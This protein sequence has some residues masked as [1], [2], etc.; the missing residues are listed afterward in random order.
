MS[1][2]GSAEHDE[3]RQVVRAFL[4]EKSAS[5]EVRRLMEAGE[6]RDDQVW[7]Q[8]A[9]QLGLTG[10]A[11]PERYG[12]A[13]YG[14][15]ELAIVLEEM[16][17]ALLVAPYLATVALAGQAL[18]ASGDEDAMA[19]WLPAIADGSLTATLAVA[20]D[21]GSWDLADVAAVAEPAGDGWVVTGTKLFVIDGHT[22][23]LLLVA[24]QAPDGPGVFAV[25]GGAA[26]LQRARLDTLDLT[27]ALAA[28][29]LRQTPAV[30]IG[31]GQDTAAWL[32]RARDLALA[33]LA[34]EQLGGAA[35]C[36]DLSVSYAKVREQF[37]RPIGSFQA[38][39]HK[40]ANLLLEVESGRSAAQH[41]SAA[42]AGGQPDA[43]LAAALAYAYCSRA[44]TRAAKECIQ[45]HGGIGYTWEHDAHLYL[46]RA[47][48]SELLFGPPARQ[49]TRLA[50]LA[51][52]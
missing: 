32:A 33:A 28:V 44:F 9:G 43:S 13:G 4:R 40:C 6:G 48:S 15:V 51:G 46:R 39:K 35:R 47:K 8:L 50:E 16:G 12:G 41:A 31:A 29:D 37:G 10:I 23:D 52:I 24:A 20:D 34:A 30:R 21:C 3:L 7:S 17:G 49:R 14:P 2:D 38:I 26:G 36:L 42:V 27:R 45:I 25:E 11:V 5:G 1:A 22:A 18:A 19:R